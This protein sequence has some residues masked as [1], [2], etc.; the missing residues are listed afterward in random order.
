M[1]RF[2]F[3][4]LSACAITGTAAAQQPPV[5]QLGPVVAKTDEPLSISGVRPI[6]GG[7][8]VND[9]RARRV[10]LFDPTL[11]RFTVV[12]DST[13][14]TANAYSGRMAGLIAYRGDSTLFVDPTSMS[15]LVLDGDGRVGRVMSVPRTQ[16]A[17]SL[18]GGPMGSAQYDPNGRLVYRASNMA[19]MTRPAGA[20]PGAMPMPPEQ[21]DS[22]P[23][24][25]VDL[26]TR[27][28]DTIAFLK[29]PR[30]RFNIVQ[31][32]GTTTMTSLVN[33]LPVVDHWTVLTDGTVAIVRGSDYR[34]DFIAP[35]G[36]RRSSPRI[37]FEWQRLSDEDKVTF[38]DSVRVAYER[39]AA[40]TP[41]GGGARAGAGAAA[42]G[43]GAGG[44]VGGQV[45]VIREGGPGGG[46]P[47]GGAM[48]APQIGFV[49]PDEL[50]DYRPAF[51]A[52]AA[53]ADQSGNVWIR[54]TRSSDG[55]TV[56]DVVNSQGQLADRV[57]V[58]AGRTIV[59]FEG[60]FVYLSSR[61]E[62]KAVLERA[63]VR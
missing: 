28:V 46:G 39:R 59:G 58:P 26:A 18:A 22:A 34:V 62:P 53:I 12:A 19:R 63:R 6:A 56:Y 16:D 17:M 57:A 5:R 36:S 38:M 13:G 10:L 42:L 27:Q 48:P 21:P 50:P 31:S 60:E 37:Q 23:L 52:G 25:R 15:M 41:Q 33:P 40:A 4:A 2:T 54:T 11:S 43:G 47:G 3:I 29:V 8:L 9:V 49:S 55:G 51:F 44:G 45:L 1:K 14:A 32:E 61:E 24:L 35:D 7:V 30:V 20:Q